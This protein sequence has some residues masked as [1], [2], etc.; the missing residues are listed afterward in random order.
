M[1]ITLEALKH[2]FTR[3]FTRR[4]PKEKYEPFPRFRGRI[5]FY[6]KRCIG[7]KLC[8]K[9]CPVKAVKFHKKGKIDFDM[10]LCIYCGLCHDVCP[11]K[12]NSIIFST[13][14]EYSDKDKKKVQKNILK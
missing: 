12:P 14:F 4:Y 11:T 3:P 10:D 5:H 2:I 7:C 6:S 13:E 8:E 1:S 9:Y